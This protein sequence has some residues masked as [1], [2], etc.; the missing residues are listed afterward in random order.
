KTF[1]NVASSWQ[2]SDSIVLSLF[3]KDLEGA[4][5]DLIRDYANGSQKL[6]L[7]QFE[8]DDYNKIQNGIKERVGIPAKDVFESSMFIKQAQVSNIQIS[9]DLR[10]NLQNV[11]SLA[12]GSTGRVNVEAGLKDLRDELNEL[13]R[14]LKRPAKNP[15]RIKATEDEL[16]EL[17]RQLAELRA[18]WQKFS[19]AKK[20]EP[21]A[22]GQLE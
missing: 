21:E 9:K 1:K 4:E 6:R 16:G 2:G 5:F 14:G 17:K 3:G 12:D 15:G 19:Q 18:E 8:T 13:E 22:G 11:S 10:N 7:S 20:S